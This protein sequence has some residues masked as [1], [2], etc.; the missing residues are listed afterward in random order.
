MSDEHDDYLWSRSGAPDPE[1]ARLEALLGRFAAPKP[2]VFPWRAL[3]AAAAVVMLAFGA[4]FALARGGDGYELRGADGVRR[5]GPGDEFVATDDAE[6]DLGRLGEVRVARGAKLRV[7]ERSEELAKLFL[8]RGTLSASVIARPRHFQIGTPAGLSV[9]LGCEYD[10]SVD[11]TGVTTLSVR[12]GRVAFETEGRK[13]LVPRG[14]SCRAVPGRGPDTP[15]F[16]GAAADFVAAVRAVEFA[17][18]PDAAAIARLVELDRR[19]DSLSLFHLLDAP[20]LEL[21]ERL[22]DRLATVYPLP[23]GVLREAVVAGSELARLAWR[24]EFESDWR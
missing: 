21:R 7:V 24:V 14:A 19:E 8:E 23:D 17:S 5:L 22:F 6:L 1:V 15:I 11:D 18:A 10:L 13:V 3:V 16:D 12:T 4:W 20:S 9:D 2:R